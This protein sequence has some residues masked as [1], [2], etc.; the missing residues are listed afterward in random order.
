MLTRDTE[1]QNQNVAG[2][3]VY[4]HGQTRDVVKNME[5]ISVG[6][7]VLLVLNV[8]YTSRSLGL[9]MDVN[10]PNNPTYKCYFVLCN[11]NLSNSRNVQNIHMPRQYMAHCFQCIS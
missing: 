7:R 3:R 4:A 11:K 1:E 5:Q 9:C 6:H 8:S 10:G 2:S